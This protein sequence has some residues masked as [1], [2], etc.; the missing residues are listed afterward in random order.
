MDD[1]RAWWDIVQLAGAGAALVLGPAAYIFWKRIQDD[2]VYLRDSDKNTLRV[3]GELTKLL[4]AQVKEDE[5]RHTN[6][7]AAVATAVDHIKGHIDARL[8][9]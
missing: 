3:L 6:I 4:E 7:I 1:L 8:P 5:N 2:T 9:K